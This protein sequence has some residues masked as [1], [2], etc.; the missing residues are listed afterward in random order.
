[1]ETDSFCAPSPRLR[2]R[3]GGTRPE[4]RQQRPV[5]GQEGRGAVGFS[6]FSKP[7]GRMGAGREGWHPSRNT[8]PLSW[9]PE[10]EG[11]QAPRGKTG[12]GTIIALSWQLL[13]HTRTHAQT[14][15][16]TQTQ[17]ILPAATHT[18]TYT[19]EYTSA[20]PRTPAW[21]AFFQAEKLI[22]G[23]LVLPLLLVPQAL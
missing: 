12:L 18:L 8:L 5:R 10:Q 1:M 19:G 14:H 7:L 9:N 2:K 20:P 13:A 3:D 17:N 23:A 21:C 22:P 6:T 15:S 11:R 16:L 4:P